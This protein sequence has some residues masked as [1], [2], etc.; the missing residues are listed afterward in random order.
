[1]LLTEL[2]QEVLSQIFSH[3]PSVQLWRVVRNVCKLLYNMLN[4]DNYW[5]RRAQV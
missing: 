3:V 5:F 4:D 2:P 1:M